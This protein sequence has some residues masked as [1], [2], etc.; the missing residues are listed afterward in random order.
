MRVAVLPLVLPLVLSVLV[1]CG[2]PS[3]LITPVSNT[4]RLQEQDVSP[5]GTRRSGAKIAVIEIEGML[6]NARRGGFLQPTE[7][8]LSLFAQQLDR[9]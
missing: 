9:A 8:K 3:L 4:S 7:N 2:T 6:I 1:G 5:A